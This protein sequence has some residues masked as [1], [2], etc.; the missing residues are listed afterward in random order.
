MF[1]YFIFVSPLLFLMFAHRSMRSSLQKI[2]E[3]GCLNRF[4]H[5]F[6]VSSFAFLCFFCVDFNLICFDLDH[7]DML[8]NRHTYHIHTFFV[9]N[10]LAYLHCIH[11]M[12]G[13]LQ[14]TIFGNVFVCIRPKYQAEK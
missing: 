9:I 4:L 5:F 2:A 13:C 8:C 14:I 11:P 6:F 10:S 12:D 3:F 7:L 1:I